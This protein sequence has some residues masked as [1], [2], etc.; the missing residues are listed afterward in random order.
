[1]ADHLLNSIDLKLSIIQNTLDSKLSQMIKL[2]AIQA[3]KDLPLQGQISMLHGVGM[4]P[5]EIATCLGRTPNT[6]RVLLHRKR[7]S[8]INEMEA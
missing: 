1:M 3:V 6:I 5:S 2:Q 7:R 4:S 8:Q